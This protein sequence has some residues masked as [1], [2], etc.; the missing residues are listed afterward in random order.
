MRRVIDVA[1]HRN[2]VLNW[3]L[4]TRFD[5][6]EHGSVRHN[7]DLVSDRIGLVYL[8]DLTGKDYPHKGTPIYPWV[9]QLRRILLC[10][11]SP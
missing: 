9:H 4:E 7:F 8:P 3:N 11:V 10:P 5:F 6:D 1:D 2:V